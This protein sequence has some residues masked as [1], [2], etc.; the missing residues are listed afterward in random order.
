[1]SKTT[2]NESAVLMCAA[3]LLNAMVQNV[4]EISLPVRNNATRDKAFQV[5]ANLAWGLAARVHALNPDMTQQEPLNN[6]P[7]E[8][9]VENFWTDPMQPCLVDLKVIASG[10]NHDV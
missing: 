9:P 6:M 7:V 5:C 10:G 1:V 8:R 2:L 3:H 4:P